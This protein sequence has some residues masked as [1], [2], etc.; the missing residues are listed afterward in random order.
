MFCIVVITIKICCL[1]P[2]FLTIYF[3]FSLSLFLSFSLSLFLS[4]SFFLSFFVCLGSAAE[5]DEIQVW[6]DVDGIMT[7]DPR[8][9]KA[10]QPVNAITYEEAAE[11]GTK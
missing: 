10:A 6:K 7:T 4:L 5:V 9:V 8:L 1:W 3:S 11:L 2:H